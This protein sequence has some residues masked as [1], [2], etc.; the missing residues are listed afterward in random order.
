MF[1]AALHLVLTLGLQ[2][3]TPQEPPVQEPPAQEAPAQAAAQPAPKPV[4]PYTD[5]A[6][7]AAVAD[8]AKSI[9][10]STSMAAR[11]AALDE[12]C[13]GAHKLLVKPLAGVV[14]G[15]KSLVVRKHAAGLLA[16]QPGGEVT[17]TL[18]RLLD[19]AD[20]ADKPTVRAELVRGLG[21]AGYHRRL[22]PRLEEQFEKDYAAASVPLQEAILDLVV[23]QKESLAIELLLRNLDEPV[24]HDVDSGSNPPKE[25]WEARW[26]A[27]KVWRSKVKDAM[28][29][30]TGQRFSSA[31]EAQAWLRKNGK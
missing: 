6:A 2:D 1:V 20:L 17:A 9:K 7:K 4:E 27:W 8:F 14:E 11:I 22:W 24:P 21:R 16:Q 30:L 19:D 23:A 25:Y 28:F 18:V 12:L 29:A 31:K 26:K 10:A 15:D 3:P 13:R 5:K